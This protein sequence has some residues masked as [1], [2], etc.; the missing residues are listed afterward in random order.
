EEGSRAHL[1]LVHAQV[2]DRRP[3]ERDDA[4]CLLPDPPLSNETGSTGRTRKEPVCDLVGG[5]SEEPE[6]AVHPPE[7][8][9]DGP[10]R[11]HVPC[12][13]QGEVLHSGRQYAYQLGGR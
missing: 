4:D 3:S 10:L 13:Y 11:D 6:R 12:R 2:R 1:R 9:Y 8:Y 7:P 5:S